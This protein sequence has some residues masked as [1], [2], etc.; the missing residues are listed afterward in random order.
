M[1][2]ALE[3]RFI[4]NAQE[5]CSNAALTQVHFFLRLSPPSPVPRTSLILF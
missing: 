2:E 4:D 1:L 3:T 5:L